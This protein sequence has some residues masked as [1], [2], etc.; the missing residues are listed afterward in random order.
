MMKVPFLIV[1]SAVKESSISCQFLFFSILIS[2]CA[3]VIVPSED[4]QITVSEPSYFGLRIQIFKLYEAPER[5]HTPSYALFVKPALPVF[6]VN[7][8]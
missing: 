3:A 4:L 6:V 7:F 5:K 2:F 1:E 8:M